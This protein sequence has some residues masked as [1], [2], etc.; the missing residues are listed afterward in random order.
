MMPVVQLLAGL[1]AIG[2]GPGAWPVWNASPGIPAGAAPAQVARVEGIRVPLPTPI[3][4]PGPRIWTPGFAPVPLASMPDFWPSYRKVP[5]GQAGMGYYHNPAAPFARRAYSEESDPVL[6]QPDQNRMQEVIATGSAPIGDGTYQEARNRAVQQ[7]L[8]TAV[9]QVTG[10]YLS[11][12][13]IT[14]KFA[15]LNERIY[16]RSEGFAVPGDV[17]E[18]S[19]TQG[20]LTLRMRV[21]VSLRPLMDS[22]RQLGLTRKW[23]VAVAICD[24]PSGLEG[25]ARLADAEITRR[26]VDAGFQVVRPAGLE[27]LD[28][29]SLPHS[30]GTSGGVPAV[31]V[32]LAGTAALHLAARAPVTLEGRVIAVI[33]IYQ[34]RIHA[35]AI[36]VETGEV[37]TVRHT[38]ELVSDR[39]DALAATA[40]V[41][42]ASRRAARLFLEDILTL[43]AS[44]TRRVRLEVD[45][46]E[47]RG[48]AQ[49]FQDALALFPGV[50]GI[51]RPEYA[52]GL[53][54]LEVELEADAAERLGTD[55]EQ[56]PGFR[57]FALT[58]EADTKARIRARARSSP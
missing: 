21:R 19:V 55:L 6:Q 42:V 46:F 35:R 57:E 47:K 41:E 48:D 30:L 54:T 20:V 33:P 22:L 16:L 3:V 39:V 4:L 13:T 58:V 24:E 37:V 8:R 26:L 34:A 50:R 12:T 10:V 45:G 52:D 7:A 36:R 38:E 1:T 53:L 14:E 18:E 5:P 32:L 23:R 40:A 25:A 28:L 2:W 56:A 27:H 51:H 44:H 49:A 9:E 15:V 17:L 43:P 11:S 29:A 31:D